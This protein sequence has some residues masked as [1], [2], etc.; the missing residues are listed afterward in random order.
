M[1]G[2]FSFIFL[3][4]ND[5]EGLIFCHRI[6]PGGGMLGNTFVIPYAQCRQQRILY[7]I[8]RQFQVMRAKDACQNSY[9]LTGF[10]AKEMVDQLGYF[11]G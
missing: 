2:K 11:D 8:L 1:G 10:D 5:I 3:P 4:A 6:Q 7:N 9:Q